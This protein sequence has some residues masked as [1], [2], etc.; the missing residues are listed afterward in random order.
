[1]PANIAHLVIAHKALKKLKS[2]EGSEVA[3]FAKII[4][5]A[6]QGRNSRA[7]MNLGSVGPDLY[8]YCNI[9]GSI[10]DMLTEGFVQ[11][12][13][14]TPWSYHL[15]S[16]QV[17][18]F[19]LRLCEILFKDVVRETSLERSRKNVKPSLDADDIRKLA[20]IAGHL[21]H[22]AA[23][24][25]IHPVVNIIAKPYYRSGEN[26]KKHRECEVFQDYYL[27]E[28]VYRGKRESLRG[29]QKA[30]YDFFEQ[31]FNEWVDC[32]PDYTTKNTEDW[33]R[34]FLQ[35]GFAETYGPFPDEDVVED[36]VDN[37]LLTL[38]TCKKLGPYK[39][40]AKDYETSGADSKMY[41]EYIKDVDYVKFYQEA[42][43]LAVVYIIA[44]FEIY[45]VLKN[46]KDFTEKH[47]ERFLNIVSDA[48][49]SCPLEQNI[50]E[51]A[52]TALMGKSGGKGGQGKY[53]Q[54]FS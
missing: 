50:Y 41:K 45:E 35:R 19:P 52:Y 44:L 38:R 13:G 12:I 17:N 39:D 5:D 42:V 26:R 16:N 7:Y 51:K 14:V 46:G 25:I 40:A 11:A 8:Y 37:L 24:Q 15:H 21:T 6:P 1:M 49:L 33:F 43:M 30:T 34:Y 10:K 31:N 3:E 32:I 53:K 9:T 18:I 48:D 20:Y 47:K 23:D 2:A 36:S 22:I 29:K 54:I 28:E 27:Y 4:D